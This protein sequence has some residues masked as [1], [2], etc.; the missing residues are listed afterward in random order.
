MNSIGISMRSYVEGFLHGAKD[1]GGFDRL[2]ALAEDCVVDPCMP[3][4]LADVTADPVDGDT[5]TLTAQAWRCWGYL[6]CHME[7]PTETRPAAS[8]AAIFV[9]NTFRD[10]T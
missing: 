2:M 9:F 3:G 8:A 7:A 4:Q 1:D 5:W 10:R 6:V